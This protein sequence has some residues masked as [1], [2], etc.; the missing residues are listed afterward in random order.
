MNRKLMPSPVQRETMHL[1]LAEST[2]LHI[3][4]VAFTRPA[5]GCVLTVHYRDVLGNSHKKSM[6]APDAKSW[7]DLED[8]VVLM[9][10]WLSHP[11]T[12]QS[13]MLQTAGNC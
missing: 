9:S 10:E 13:D 7:S 4:Q 11:T 12:T 1:F 2:G 5:S 3:D 8:L 6:T